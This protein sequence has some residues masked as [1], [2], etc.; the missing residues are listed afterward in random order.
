MNRR[1]ELQLLL[2]K[3]CVNQQDLNGGNIEQ[4]IIQGLC[5][6][7]RANCSQHYCRT[8]CYKA[9]LKA[10]IRQLFSSIRLE[11]VTN[12]IQQSVR[13]LKG[14]D[15]FVQYLYLFHN[16]KL[17]KCFRRK[18]NKETREAVTISKQYKNF[19]QQCMNK[20]TKLIFFLNLFFYK[21]NYQ[22]VKQN[23]KVIKRNM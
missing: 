13:F 20:R 19:E 14:Q 17:P 1:Q 18:Q 2:D 9:L 23:K 3:T 11:P 8:N 12:I 7:K 22:A 21:P 6:L 10:G 15:L 5:R 16:R 4:N